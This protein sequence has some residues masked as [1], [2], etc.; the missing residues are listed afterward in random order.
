MKSEL[1]VV[2]YDVDKNDYRDVA[3]YDERR[4]VGSA[5]EYKKKV[6]SNAYKAL[7]GSLNGKRVLD[8]GCGT[9][10]GLADFAGEARIAIGTDASRDMLAVAAQKVSALS[11]TGV[12]QSYAQHL[13]FPDAYFDVVVALNFLHLFTLQ[14]QRD[15]V[16]E[17]KRVAKP[18]GIIVLE[19]DNALHGLIIGLYKRWSGRERGALPGEIAYIIGNDCRVGRIYG[20]VFPIVWRAFHHFS[21]L[22]T[23][24][25][26]V[27]Y[28]P[29]LN[30]LS[31]RVF[32]KL[33]KEA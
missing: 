20:A 15:M 27:A 19:F 31:H 11:G 18:G 22:F 5:N 21:S 6:M 16:G 14:T 4:Y 13:P 23:Q 29:P 3:N 2:R 32:Y 33:L 10:R 9:G 12:V 26:K 28:Y 25:E 30:R 24:V 7:M 1:E 8:V 17:M